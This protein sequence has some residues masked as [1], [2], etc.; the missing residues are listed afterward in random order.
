MEI[1]EGL[2]G[3]RQLPPGTVLSVGNF[4]GL[5]R[6]HE[7]LLRNAAALKQSGQAS[8]V[9]IVTFEPHPLTVLRP[10]LAPPRLTPPL[11]KQSLLAA[12]GVDHLVILPPAP[13]VLNLTA[14]DFWHILRDEVRPAHMIEGRS[15]TFGKN[16]GGNIGKLKEWAAGSP[17]KLDIL[18]PVTVALLNR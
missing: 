2:P 10:D 9:A 7:L 16:R 4:D 13:Q 5:H 17:I 18:E 14:E 3:L 12:A 1:L 8:A 15:F 11:L 6:G